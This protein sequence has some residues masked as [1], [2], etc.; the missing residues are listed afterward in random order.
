MALNDTSNRAVITEIHRHCYGE[1]TDSSGQ[2]QSRQMIRMD[3]MWW[4]ALSRA[5]FSH[6]EKS[7]YVNL[8]STDGTGE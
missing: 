7:N 2:K 5:S 4:Y 6:K 8:R 3:E 1:L